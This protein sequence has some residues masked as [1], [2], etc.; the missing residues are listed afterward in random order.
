MQF[1][2]QHS[3]QREDC[4]AVVCEAGRTFPRPRQ[5]SDMKLTFSYRCV[6]NR[7][8]QKRQTEQDILQFVRYGKPSAVRRVHLVLCMSMGIAK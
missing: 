4:F 2:N 8:R 5:H 1:Y 3:C 6:L 7:H